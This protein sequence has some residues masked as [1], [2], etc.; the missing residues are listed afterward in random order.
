MNTNTTFVN[1]TGKRIQF[2]QSLMFG[3]EPLSTD[4]LAEIGSHENGGSTVFL[5]SQ[6]VPKDDLPEGIAVVRT[7]EFIIGLPSVE[8]SRPGQIFIVPAELRSYVPRNRQ[9]ILWVRPFKWWIGQEDRDVIYCTALEG[10]A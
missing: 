7:E 6:R 9:D 1:L 10:H 8:A 4:M 5:Y 3:Q 2:Y